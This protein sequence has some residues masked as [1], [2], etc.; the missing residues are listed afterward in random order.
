ML[1]HRPE[2]QTTDQNDISYK[3][4]F[5]KGAALIKGS[6]QLDG[7][8][9]GVLGFFERRKL[10]KALKHFEEASSI[11]PTNG[12]PMLFIAKIKQRFGDYDGSLEWLKR[13]NA[14]EPGNLIL[15]IET[16]ATLGRLGKHKEAAAMLEVAAQHH[17]QEP[18]I[19]CNLGLSYLMAGET[20]DALKTFQFLVQLEPDFPTNQKL[21][22]LAYEI[23]LGKK[24]TPKNEAE[25]AR[26]F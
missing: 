5:D 20:E 13:A 14:V 4:A 21:L 18:R 19:L 11:A 15:A 25:I 3:A 9:L 23:R 7:Q 8:Q 1:E 6:I 10:N 17:P 22:G 2:M 24:S 12:A 16:G 26:M